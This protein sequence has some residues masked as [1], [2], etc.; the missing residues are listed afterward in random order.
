MPQS[1]AVILLELH[2]RLL[3]NQSNILG[4]HIGITVFIRLTGPELVT[5]V[6]IAGKA[7]MGL[8]RPVRYVNKV[9]PNLH[10]GVNNWARI[11]DIELY[12]LISK[13]FF[14]AVSPDVE[15]LTGKKGITLETF[16]SE[17]ANVFNQGYI[18]MESKL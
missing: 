4:K 9:S 12:H 5:G 17:S 8:Q 1:I 16:F 7:S 3:T 6:Q 2:Q 13:G 11:L 10:S 14:T 18:S 15:Q